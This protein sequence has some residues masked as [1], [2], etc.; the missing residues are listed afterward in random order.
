MGLEPA[1]VFAA[2]EV[3][4]DPVPAV[5]VN[6]PG[7]LVGLLGVATAGAVVVPYLVTNAAGSVPAPR[8]PN[9]GS[10][11]FA[12]R[13]RDE[14]HS[15]S[16]GRPVLFL[17]LDPEPVE[18]VRTA[19]EDARQ[20]PQLKWG[21]LIERALSTFP[22]L[23]SLSQAV[24]ADI[25]A[26]DRLPHDAQDLGVLLQVLREST[27]DADL[28]ARLYRLGCYLSDPHVTASS[29]ARL[30]LG[31]TWRERLERWSAPGQD[32]AER[33]TAVYGDATAPGRQAILKAATAFGLDY[34]AFT[35][36][37]LPEDA[38][39]DRLAI[40]R[41]VRVRGAVAV[42]G[43]EGAAL[44][45]P[46]GG[47]FAVLL[48]GTPGR[49][50]EATISW[51][52]AP[53][54]KA[55]IDAGRHELRVSCDA[56]AEWVF[57]TLALGQSDRLRLAVFT[58]QGSWFPAEASLDIDNQA[59]CFRYTGE[60]QVVAVGSTAT[61]VSA[62]TVEPLGAV[63]AGE[64]VEYAATYGGETH[65]IV[66]LDAG[67]VGIEPPEEPG[68][69]SPGE[70]GDG[71]YAGAE[72]PL[73][74]G[75]NGSQRRQPGFQIA[76]AYPSVP[77]AKLEV[78]RRR[79]DA[80]LG[81]VT[82]G[83][84]EGRGYIGVGGALP[85]LFPQPLT[86]GGASV[87][88]LDLERLVLASP[89]NSAY[90][91]RVEDG[92]LRLEPDPL[93][94]RLAL[95]DLG[96]TELGSFWDARRQLFE[97]LA[98]HGSVHAVAAGVAREEAARYIEAYAQ[99][100][101]RAAGGGPF[102]AEYERVILCDAVT[103]VANGEILLA[104]TNPVTVAFLRRLDDDVTS[105]LPRA[106]EALD[107]DLASCSVRH[108]LPT[109]ALGGLWYESVG[110]N[111]L[112]WRRYRQLSSSGAGTDYDPGYIT[113][114]LRHFL[115]VFPAY[116]DARQVLAVAFVE[117]GDGEAILTALRR[118]YEPLA[119]VTGSGPTA[120]LPSLDVTVVT[121]TRPEKLER[122]MSAT[123]ELVDAVLRDRV[124][125]T[126]AGPGEQRPEFAH[127]T[128][129]F[130]SLL[131]REP[132]TVDLSARASTLYV[133]GLAS[134][135]GRQTTP[136][137]NETQFAWGTFPGRA[138]KPGD[139][140]E[141]LVRASLELVGG[142]PRDHIVPN[143]TRMPSTRV[144]TGF[145]TEIYTRS[146]WVV[147]LDRLLGLEA[148][149]PGATG[150]RP[151]YLIDYEDRAE[152]GQPGLDAI[153]ATE[154]V[155]PYH[156]ALRRVV[157]EVGT[158][159]PAAL[160]RILSLLNS[161][162]GRW[163]LDLVG[164]N[165]SRLRERIGI[166]AGI[167]AVAELD[168]AFAPNDDSVTVMLALNE[169]LDALPTDGRTRPLGQHCDDLL[170][171]TLP[172]AD[173]LVRI[174]GRLLEVKY[175]GVSDP[176]LPA[177]ARPQLE[178]ARDWF[179]SKF[180]TDGPSRL[181]RAR[182]LSEL[183]RGGIARGQAFGLI[184]E[185]AAA[186]A[187][188]AVEDVL[189][190][191]SQGE[192]HLDLSFDVDS[193]RF[194]GEF[195]SVEAD[196]GFAAH[197]QALPGTGQPLSWLRLGRP[198]LEAL[199]AASS[200]P[201][202]ATFHRATVPS[203]TPTEEPGVPGGTGP[204]EGPDTARSP[205]GPPT[206]GTMPTETAPITNTAA[207]GPGSPAVTMRTDSSTDPETRRVAAELTD[208]AGKYGINLEPFD[209]AL[210]EIGPSVI[211]LRTRLLGRQTLAGV[212]SRALD[213]G[214]EAGIAEGL[215]IDQEPYYVTVDVPR[216][217]RET[218][219]Y[220]D[221]SH[222]LDAPAEPGALNFLLG[223]A[224]SGEVRI[225][226]LARLPHLLVAGATGSGKSVFLRGLVS[227][228]VRTRNPSGLQ[229]LVCDPQT[230]NYEPF[231]GSVH[232]LEG[233]IITDPLEMVDQLTD[234]LTRELDRRRA[235][236]REA[237]VTSA[238]EFYEDGGTLDELQQMVIII[239]EFADLV[240]ALSRDARA[241]FLQ[242]VKR[243]AQ[244]TRALGIYLVLATQRPSVQIISGDIKTNLTARVA[245]RMQVPQDSITILGRGGAESLRDKG[246]LLFDHAGR[247]ERLQGFL[248]TPRD[249]LAEV[250][251][252]QA[253]EF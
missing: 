246:D 57:G 138:P 90:A 56:T 194:H 91:A 130:R 88:G 21:D 196:S 181:F 168:E 102:R 144:S 178:T 38:P 97:V 20:L 8:K 141:G 62:P 81:S 217:E 9:C 13:L 240:D 16:S 218:V 147:H 117:P 61:I 70:P 48:R 14:I 165:S 230:V 113:R 118:F 80:D 18:T 135:P 241:T 45:L 77:H 119:R 180:N 116:A 126:V 251:R 238:L 211:R 131:H 121:S 143:H 55:V 75:G 23:P 84:A 17:V 173:G 210:A 73:R 202:P 163:A 111:P 191:V 137:R 221:Y 201:R 174:S 32:L 74:G 5:V 31:A 162:S 243:F 233:R 200:V 3:D 37:D 133:S 11:G 225:A 54:S 213:L 224:P 114:R 253:E 148:F 206:G 185:M 151:R 49:N 26:R 231:E 89:E 183:I 169:V 161:V 153:T 76:D 106:A 249:A 219:R 122:A 69:E 152:P 195:I 47:T 79:L 159:R 232:L 36:N 205:G 51:D 53:S 188:E 124:S 197:R 68:G 209:P 226:D 63:V 64:L 15:S 22:G 19:A 228:L 71:S 109:F 7:G 236:L 187:L 140:L 248:C 50:D 167:A 172:L 220:S 157:A 242:N 229:L 105:W 182:D 78:A 189:E 95:D 100:L 177:M 125:L 4:F 27:T 123:E 52:A 214:R 6:T 247:L 33:L 46:G 166:V 227:S 115:D 186:S 25:I 112:L 120:T 171:L 208:A 2:L 41:P 145:L 101:E 87:D 96:E 92:R 24:V 170:V 190:R 132:A 127:L 244:M 252:W 245:L 193:R 58:G 65:P 129:I 203:A 212:Q 94:E 237:R 10:A 39:A 149:A 35:L 192:F 72:P 83:V 107:A 164:A 136:G 150:E 29:A 103:D 104:P 67:E 199:A 234:T 139:S 175:R 108:L 134:A 160:D 239:D 146:V 28:G 98:A 128:F 158:P 44:W 93:L 82:F 60:P 198:V 156:L 42:A 235:R 222:L 216:A 142:M 154:R 155:E 34:S 184:P 223:V 59:G 43:R 204:G 86:I 110:G 66:L 12:A 99:L 1:D 250:H 207:D 85:I 215:L 176:D 40:A 179:L 30:R